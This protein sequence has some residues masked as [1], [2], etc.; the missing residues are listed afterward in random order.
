V[1]VTFVDLLG[2]RA[3]TGSG[4]LMALSRLP[5]FRQSWFDP[6]DVNG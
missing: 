1:R 6:A 4:T 2:R 5:R 3:E